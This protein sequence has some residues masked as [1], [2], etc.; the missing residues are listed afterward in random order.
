M[1]LLAGGTMST[2]FKRNGEAPN[3]IAASAKTGPLLLLLSF[4]ALLALFSLAL[5][6]LLPIAGRPSMASIFCYFARLGSVL[7]GSGYVLLAFLRTDLVSH[8]RWLSSSQLLDA[9][10]IGQITPGPVFTTATFIGYLLNGIPGALSATIGIFAPAFFFV[11]GTAAIA[12]NIRQSA[13]SSRFID[14]VNVA[15]ISLMMIVT[16]QIACDSLTRLD[17]AAIFI[18]SFALLEKCKINSAILIFAGAA[19]EYALSIMTN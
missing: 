1:A 11:A 19:V 14:G 13:L 2:F 17:A 7:Y 15:S 10:A 6:Y 5:H 18:V 4:V 12:R 16:W 9:V 3:T 8:F